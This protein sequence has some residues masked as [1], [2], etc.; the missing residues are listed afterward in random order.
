MKS[1]G[2]RF[3]ETSSTGQPA[4]FENQAEQLHRFYDV[5]AFRFGRPENRQVAILFDDIT[6][7]KKTEDTLRR[8]AALPRPE[9]RRHHG[10]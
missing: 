3:T 8:Q 2:L 4:R 1:I 6:E 7:R 5:Y 10:P 9:P